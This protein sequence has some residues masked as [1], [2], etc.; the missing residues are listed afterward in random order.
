MRWCSS[1]RVPRSSVSST[2][3]DAVSMARSQSSIFSYRR[4][5]AAERGVAVAVE[6]EDVVVRL[7]GAVGVAQLLFVDLA[8]L[9]VEIDAHRRIVD[10]VDVPPQ[11]L[12]QLGRAALLPIKPLERLQRRLVPIVDEQDLLERLPRAL[13]LAELLLPRRRH[14]LVQRDALLVGARDV[15]LLLEHVEVVLHV[16]GLL[17]QALERLERRDVLRIDRQDLLVR[18]DGARAVA[19]P[20]LVELPDLV[21]EADDLFGVLDRPRLL[22]QDLD[23][24]RPLLRGAIEPLERVERRHR[25]RVGLERRLVRRHRLSLIAERAFPQLGHGQVQLDLLLR[26]LLQLG[27]LVERRHQL[28]PH[29]LLAVEAGEVLQRLGVLR[30]QRQ[31]LLLRGDGVVEV[32]EV[33]AVP[34]ADLDP[35]VRRRRRIG[36][37]LHDL[38]VLG[39]A[40]RSTCSSP[41]PA[42][43]ARPRPPGRR[44]S[45]GTP[46][47]GRRTRPPD[48]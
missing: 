2:S 18:L 13:G 3:R 5:S 30:R 4:D 6:A 41:S 25:L 11:R 15:E 47:G 43:R 44:S 10:G 31:R 17:V 12:D 7:D 28:R 37:L 35:Q 45:R 1:T 22:R 19:E 16:A 46:P 32:P 34:A 27:V 48:R 23:E 9:P 21:L 42:A 39:R 36:D 38:R 26:L 20:L 33:L 40:G 14:A 24:V 8:H 29:R